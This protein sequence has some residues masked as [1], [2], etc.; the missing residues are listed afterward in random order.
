MKHNRTLRRGLGV[1]LA[2]VMCLSLLPATALAA[3]PATATADFTTNADGA[4]AL[5]NGAKTEGAAD[6]EWDPY[7]STLTLN[8]VNF[9][10][11]APIAVELPAGAT[12]YLA[13][14][15]TNTIAS[16]NSS[17]A[18]FGIRCQGGS[19]NISGGGSLTI[20]VSYTNS[21]GGY[22]AFGIYAGSVTMTG[23]TV[24]IVASNSSYSS[25]GVFASEDLSVTGGHLTANITTNQEMGFGLC[26][27]GGEIAIGDAATVDVTVTNSGVGAMYG[28]YNRAYTKGI[29]DNGNI[30]L[31]GTVT[32][33]RGSS[34]TGKVF[35][36]ANSG[37]GYNPNGVISVTGGS[38]TVTDAYCGIS[39]ATAGHTGAFSDVVISG[40]T[41]NIT[42][43]EAHSRGIVSWK[44]GV[45]IAGGAVTVST[46]DPAL[47]LDDADNTN[48]TGLVNISGGAAVSL[49]SSDSKALVVQGD[50]SVDSTRTH[51]IDLA[52]GG[53]VTIKSTSSTE[54]NVLFPEQGYFIL[55]SH[56]A[57]TEGNFRT[58]DINAMGG[59]TL[60]S[61]STSKQVVVAYQLS[62]TPSATVS[63]ATVSGNKGV[64][65]TD[66][67][68]TVTLLN[69]T[70]ASTLSGSWIT[71]LPAGLSQTVTRVDDTHAKITISGT[72]MAI[73]VAAMAITIPANQLTSN[74]ALTVTANANAKFDIFVPVYPVRFNANGGSG[75]MDA[76]TGVSGSYTLPTTATFTAP[77]GKQFAGW[78]TSADGEVITGTTITVTEDTTLYAVWAIPYGVTVNDDVAVTDLNKDDVLGNGLVRYDPDTNTVYKAKGYLATL[79]VAGNGSTDVVISSTSS[80]PAVG[81]LTVTGAKDVTVTANSGAP[82]I[83]GE[84]NITCTGNVTIT[85]SNGM[86]ASAPLTVDGAQNV[87]VEGSGNQAI[88][89]KTMITCSGNV[90]IANST[91]M[92]VSNQLTV[93]GAKDV[94]VTANSSAPTIAGEA[95]ITCSGKVDIT[96]STG[97]A[98]NSAL[99]VNKAKDVTVIANSSYPAIGG[100]ADITCSGKVDIT[101]STGMAVSDAL[102]VKNAQDVTVTANT[103]NTEN[104][105]YP[106]IGGKADITCSGDVTISNSNSDGR[107]VGNGLTYQSTGDHGYT[108]KTG[109]SL[110]SLTDYAIKEADQVFEIESLD[111]PAVKIS[112]GHT[113][114]EW[115]SDSTQHWQ[116]CTVCGEEFN[117]ANH[118]FIGNTCT[119]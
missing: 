50:S 38:V 106:A 11:T 87:T 12:I 103:E 115:H 72:P 19:L 66:I 10:T 52:S 77:S 46:V 36:I 21:T 29:G 23:G 56:T 61:N 117:R 93:T 43:S 8:G 116:V 111:A 37:N 86:A 17:T 47:A 94:T 20:N 14:G 35:G 85:N 26:C 97:M 54:N 24:N 22:M 118:T 63:D 74:A 28:I 84:A 100:T 59:R 67:D 53:S 7:T 79:T 108:V 57:I 73:S 49:T 18:V 55:G 95:D 119:V 88:A 102:T 32:V 68:V 110:D 44:N 13:E 107:A 25:Y 64:A 90:T 60:Q 96:N 104:T 31:A 76:V 45:S 30:N 113:A 81:A 48:Q 5:L 114:D 4:L 33:T 34:A 9:T 92:A 1:L 82:A 16:T 3:E 99:T 6:S 71:N 39:T 65:I 75:E 41:V 98:V 15:T 89:G 83:S 78:A 58:N 105:D 62:A 27:Q 112:V 109:P 40:G 51:Q 80:A 91:G 101:N 42:S 70:F 69:D 2:L